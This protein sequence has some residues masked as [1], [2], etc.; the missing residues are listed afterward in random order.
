M[1]FISPAGSSAR[2]SVNAAAQMA[3]APYGLALERTRCSRAGLRRE[4]G[5]RLSLGLG[6]INL[7]FGMKLML[8]AV[9]AAIQAQPRQES[10]P[11]A[12]ARALQM[13]DAAWTG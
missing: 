10:H 13:I 2:L 1:P 6:Y 12:A 5:L 3:R 9:I 11:C 4:A 7:L 8:A